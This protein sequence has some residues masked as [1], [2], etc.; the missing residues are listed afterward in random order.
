MIEERWLVD[1]VGYAIASLSARDLAVDIGANVGEWTRE[2]AGIFSSVIAY[3]PDPRAADQIAAA[4][5]VTVRRVAV[6]D[7]NGEV[8]FHLRPDPAQNSILEVHPIG[9]GGQSAAPV[10]KS[11]SV[12]CITM[13]TA[14][15]AGADFVKIDIEGGEVAALDGCS[16]AARWRRTA[17]VVEC[18]NTA[19]A[20]QERLLGL[21]KRIQLYRHPSPTAHPGH[22]WLIGLP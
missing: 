19:T 2:L 17:F 3:E 18:H 12:P 4:E 14:F 11:V 8:T 21:G 22:C 15:P 20:V 1:P 9:A 7:K 16:D 6:A 10:E 13:D 5:N